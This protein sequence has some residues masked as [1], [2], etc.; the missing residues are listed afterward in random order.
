MRTDEVAVA[1]VDPG[2]RHAAGNHPDRLTVE[3]LIVRAASGAVGEY[4]GRLPASAG[5]SAALRVVGRRRRN[6]AQIDQVQL[7]DVDAQFHRRRAE[8]ERKLAVTEAVLPLL[9]VLR[10]HLRGVLAC[11]EDTPEVH[12]ASIALHEVAIHLK[13]QPSLVRE[14]G[15]VERAILTGTG[16]PAQRVG[17]KLVAWA[18]VSAPTPHLLD[19]AVALQGQKQKPDDL[20]GFGASNAVVRSRVRVELAP[21]VLS[22]SAVR[23][24]EQPESFPLPP[25]ARPG[26][27]C[28][29][30]LPFVLQI[31]GCAFLEAWFR[32]FDQVVLLA[33]IEH[34]DLYRKLPTEQVE[35]RAN[36]VFSQLARGYAE[37]RG[38]LIVRKPGLPQFRLIKQPIFA[39][40]P[41]VV[42]PEQ[43]AILQVGRRYAPP[44][45]KVPVDEILQHSR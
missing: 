35:Q 45:F 33:R 36:E 1:K 24:N 30:Q 8:H 19:N 29:G 26:D 41:H 5:A 15:A 27:D 38:N 17:V 44:A 21:E 34:I 10:R 28:L 37:R 4:H 32:L 12:E 16:Q 23:G 42:E 22:V 6:V 25:G 39:G 40:K 13:R 31:P 11:L 18:V 14:A 20:V 2:R 7:L 3:V 43:A 9:P